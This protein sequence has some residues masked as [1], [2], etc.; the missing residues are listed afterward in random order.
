VLES[1]KIA[2]TGAAQ[3]MMNDPRVRDVYL[4]L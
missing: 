2:L 3:D 1:G 4:G